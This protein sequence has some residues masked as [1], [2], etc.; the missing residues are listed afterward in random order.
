LPSYSIAK[1]LLPDIG[2]LDTRQIGLLNQL[3]PCPSAILELSHIFP[4][5]YKTESN[6]ELL[7]NRVRFTIASRLVSTTNFHQSIQLL[8][9]VILNHPNDVHLLYAVSRVYFQMGNVQEARLLN[10]RT[11]EIIS[12]WS[13]QDNDLLSCLS[14]NKAYLALSEDQ[15][16]KAIQHFDLAIEKNNTNFEAIA[17]RALCLLHV[18]RLD[19]AIKSLET[20]LAGS[21]ESI[22][23]TVVFNLCTLY[24]LAF[25]DNVDKKEKLLLQYHN[26]LPDD[27]DLSVFKLT[28]A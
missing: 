5:V 23:E 24:D 12:K 28:I 27:F 1:D 14:V 25:L 15:P 10:S 11:E 19:E 3:T 4:E 13:S 17:N 16:A 18:C 7:A 26:F 6:W 20:L 2:T 22:Q 9:E 21:P 8:S